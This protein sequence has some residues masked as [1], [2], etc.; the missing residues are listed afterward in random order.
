MPKNVDS[1]ISPSMKQQ[2]LVKNEQL[3]D[4]AKVQNS[5]TQKSR[6]AADLSA[7]IK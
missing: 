5:G 1:K 6:I 4:S 7:E 3:K 2:S